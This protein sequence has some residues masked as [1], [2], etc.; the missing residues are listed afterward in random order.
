MA[1]RLN[2]AIDFDDEE[3]LDPI[4]IAGSENGDDEDDEG[5]EIDGDDD[6]E[7]VAKLAALLPEPIFILGSENEALEEPKMQ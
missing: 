5:N 2:G 1:G 7:D 6:D 4:L 3:P